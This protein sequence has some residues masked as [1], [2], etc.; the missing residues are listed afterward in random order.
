MVFALGA[1]QACG[2]AAGEV[3]TALAEQ[4][5]A[6]CPAM[7]AGLAAAAEAVLRLPG[8]CLKD[9]AAAADTWGQETGCSPASLAQKSLRPSAWSAVEASTTLSLLLTLRAPPQVSASTGIGS[10]HVFSACVMLNDLHVA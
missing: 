7:W 5:R 10:Y 8:D 3:A 1:V 2:Q 9:A 4:W 6:S